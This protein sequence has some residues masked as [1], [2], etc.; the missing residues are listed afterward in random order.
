MKEGEGELKRNTCV[1]DLWKP[2]K[3]E[4]KSKYV[5]GLIFRYK[6]PE[7]SSQL[8]RGPTIV[9]E[10]FELHRSDGPSQNITR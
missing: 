8:F 5:Q 3:V 9:A 4:C 2:A 6:R 7:T 10:K 1:Y